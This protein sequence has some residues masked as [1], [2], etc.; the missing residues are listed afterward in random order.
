MENFQYSKNVLYKSKVYA[1][2]NVHIGD[3]YIINGI[4]REI[5]LQLN[6]IPFIDKADV[7]GR[8]NDLQKINKL[9][10]NSDKLVLVNGLGGIGKTTLAK[11]FI[12][13]FKEQFN[14]IAWIKITSNIKESFV[15]DRQLVDSLCLTEELENLAKNS[16]WVNEAF[17]LLTNRMK[18]LSSE[19]VGC[20]NLLIIDNITE[21]VEEQRLIDAISLRPNWKVLVTSRQQLEGFELY[22]LGFLSL[23][24]SKQLFYRHFNREQND[25][26]VEE[27]VQMVGLHTLTIELLAKTVQNHFGLNLQKLKVALKKE[28]LNI[29]KAVAIKMPNYD[30]GEVKTYIF[31]CLEVAFDLTDFVENTMGL[32]ILTHFSIL[33]PNNIPYEDIKVL[34]GVKHGNEKSEADLIDTLNDLVIKGWLSKTENGY[35]GHSVIL[36]I[37]RQK[38]KPTHVTCLFLIVNLATKLKNLIGTKSHDI[39]KY[40]PYGQSVLEILQEE[41][42]PLDMLANNL[43]ECY[44]QVGLWTL[45]FRSRVNYLERARRNSY[46]DISEYARLN[47]G[48]Y[49]SNLALSYKNMYQIEGD[50]K[51]MEVGLGYHLEA[52]G[53]FEES[54]PTSSK[55]INVIA[56]GYDLLSQYYIEL[57]NADLAMETIR[58]SI[59]FKKNHDAAMSNEVIAAS[60]AILGNLLLESG[61]YLKAE[62][63]LNKAMHILVNDKMNHQ[64]KIAMLYYGLSKVCYRLEEFEKAKEHQLKGIYTFEEAGFLLN[65]DMASYFENAADIYSRLGQLKPMINFYQKALVA[66]SELLGKENQHTKR[67]QLLLNTIEK[68]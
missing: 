12:A 41:S 15:N 36:D 17:D 29:S 67:I 59:E 68:G 1:T 27:I 63:T 21:E 11:Y 34:F 35:W 7:I 4:Q 62:E 51:L 18:Q 58:K 20:K 65:M 57:N 50:I 54:K 6:T 43:F 46:T 61:A 32:Y 5:P 39:L 52:I 25:E 8:D 23:P 16:K 66:Y 53:I 31:K 3:I 30:R 24:D 10:Q 9:L 47:F 38:E 64:N 45:A 19:E 37:I 42:Q 49:L 2:G 56:A 28:G 48:I 14:Y 33:P 40:L 13:E 55:E 44:R 60:F 22:E 26:L